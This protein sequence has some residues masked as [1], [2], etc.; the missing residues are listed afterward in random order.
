MG[1]VCCAQDSEGLVSTTDI[2]DGRKP[3]LFGT[4]H[5]DSESDNESDGKDAT[6]VEGK[7]HL[8]C[9]SIVC[10]IFKKKILVERL[11][12]LIPRIRAIK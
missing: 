6:P 1:V 5:H 9:L 11:R 4:V 3:Q 7:S 12:E 8:L 2:G 10:L